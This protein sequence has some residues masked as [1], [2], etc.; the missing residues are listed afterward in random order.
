MGRFGGILTIPL[1]AIGSKRFFVELFL[2]SSV[3]NLQPSGEGEN[4]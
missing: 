4:V 3:K 1:S 2:V